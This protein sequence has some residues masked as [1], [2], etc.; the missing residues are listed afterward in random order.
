MTTTPVAPSVELTFAPSE[1]TGVT[2]QGRYLGTPA[3]AM[4]AAIH[5]SRTQ[6]MA[7]LKERLSSPGEVTAHTVIALADEA[8]RLIKPS[9]LRVSIPVLAEAYG[10][11]YAQANAGDISRGA[12][13][14]V[15]EHHAD[16]LGEYYHATA[17]EAMVEGFNTYVN[18]RMAAR[19]AANKVF[20]A[21]GLS[22]RQMRGYI[23]AQLVWDR[24]ITSLTPLQIKK[25]AAKY[26]VRSLYQRYKTITA[27]ELHRV[28]EEGK[29]L[30]WMYRL[31]KGDLPA[32]AEKMWLTAKDERVCP[33]C[34][35]LHGT[36]VPITER[37]ESAEGK[38]WA[39][40]VHPNCR[41]ELRL[42]PH[43][44]RDINEVQKDLSGNQLY[45]FNRKHP[46]GEGGR[47]SASRRGVG[48]IDVDDEFRIL[49]GQKDE[50]PS[51]VTTLTRTDPKTQALF[52]QVIAQG[53]QP[54]MTF[55]TGLERTP[56]RV[57]APAR[58]R[59]PAPA[60]EPIRVRTEPIKVVRPK[61]TVETVPEHQVRGL[62]KPITQPK[63]KRKT[64]T[65]TNVKT[66]VTVYAPVDPEMYNQAWRNRVKLTQGMEFTSSQG[67][68]IQDVQ[69][70]LR[71]QVQSEVDLV[72]SHNGGIFTRS[73]DGQQYVLT[74]DQIREVMDYY[75]RK[76]PYEHSHNPEALQRVKP[77]MIQA[78][79]LD[80]SG[81]PKVSEGGVPFTATYS[82]RFIGNQWHLDTIDWHN[83]VVAANQGHQDRTYQDADDPQKYS[84]DGIFSRSPGF[85]IHTKGLEYPVIVQAIKPRHSD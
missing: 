51:R 70:G 79:L 28:S 31:E 2:Q 61:V 65:D 37:F 1:L 3:Q 68:A 50:G 10:R 22:P 43:Q 47:F 29:S 4:T 77:P 59:A 8:W 40:G 12:L 19:A 46:R 16:E 9:F 20:E 34:G 36:K 74:R 11:A 67:A 42:L 64:K 23:A 82:A 83:E 73:Q 39:P 54:Q 45:D 7:E 57:A 5:G 35:P 75:V 84:F 27:H 21:Y 85:N 58:T 49:T 38:F 80:A 81:K 62:T 17:R 44:F 53:L 56:V 63:T 26:I 13:Y 15:A 30:A 33:V 32:H 48:T 52:E 78:Q 71:E 14:A 69:E 76:A 41:C 72:G 60:P 66:G 6:M 55:K 25:E 18:R 24:K